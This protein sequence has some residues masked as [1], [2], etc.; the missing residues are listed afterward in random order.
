M[1]SDEVTMHTL[2]EEFEDVEE[3]LDDLLIFP[4]VNA[5]RRSLTLIKSYFAHEH[6]LMKQCKFSQDDY[7]SQIAEQEQILS[8]VGKDMNGQKSPTAP[9]HCKS[10]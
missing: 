6:I 1:E 8:I 10:D 4:S 9:D 2:E 3:S 7:T 5:L